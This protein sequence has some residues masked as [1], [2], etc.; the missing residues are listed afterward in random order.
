[1]PAILVDTNVIIDF[2]RGSEL[3]KDFLMSDTDA[4]TM[5]AAT[6]AELYA[7]VREG[8]ERTVLDS[9]VNSFH[10]LP[11]DADTAKRGGL[12]FREFNKSHGT[13]LV[14]AIIAATA[15]IH[16]CELAT[17]NKK[18]FPMLQHVLVPYGK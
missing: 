6:V 10:V 5:S 7:G 1:M 14:D 18:H 8:K 16:E 12:L 2:L 17:L 15:L 11:V 3:A 4:N 9:V 13:D